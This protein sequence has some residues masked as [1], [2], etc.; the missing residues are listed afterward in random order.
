MTEQPAQQANK[1]GGKWMLLLLFVFFACPLLIVVTMHALDVRPQGKSNGTLISPSVPIKLM[2]G[3][4]A[5]V[6]HERWSLVYVAD[7]CE[8]KCMDALHDMRQVHVSLAKEIS[9]VQRVLVTKKLENETVAKLYPD[10]VVL[11]EPQE[12][13]ADLTIQFS[14]RSGLTEAL[15]LV[16]PL[17]NFV[18]VYKKETPAQLVRADL[19]KLLK[20]SW[21][22]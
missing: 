13:V 17:G 6:W 2:A 9:R 5:D 16:D 14:H 4:D 15:Y 1:A 19:M 20:F 22:G 7:A 12:A 3:I 10:L 11:S 18:M 21:A 8:Q